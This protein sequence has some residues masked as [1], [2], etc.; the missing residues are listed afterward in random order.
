VLHGNPRW[1]FLYRHPIHGLSDEHRCVALDCLGFGL[2]EDPPGF[3]YR[4]ADHAAVVGEFVD[5]LDLT[6]LTLLVHDWGGPT[7]HSCALDRPENVRALIVCNSWFWPIEDDR[8]VR[9]FSRLLGGPVGRLLAERYDAFARYV[10]RGRDRN[11][12]RRGPTPRAARRRGTC[13][14]RRP[15]G[16]VGASAPRPR[17]RSP[18]RGK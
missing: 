17:R 10:S 13:R 18:S 12:A 9:L 14:S 3:S 4:P 8:T 1:S 2:S 16:P 7:G 6:D 11:R 15:T 5:E